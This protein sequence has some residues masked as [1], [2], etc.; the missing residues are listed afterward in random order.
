MS[1]FF[2]FADSSSFLLDLFS[3]FFGFPFFSYKPPN[4]QIWTSPL[5]DVVAASTVCSFSSTG[6]NSIQKCEYVIL[7]WEA[8]VAFELETLW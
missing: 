8:G 2:F 3:S 1:F 7:H 5:L 4:I 6:V